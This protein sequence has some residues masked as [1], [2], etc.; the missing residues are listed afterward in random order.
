MRRGRFWCQD[1]PFNV[2]GTVP[3][4]L[5]GLSPQRRQNRPSTVELSQDR[6]GERNHHEEGQKVRIDM[7]F[8]GRMI[9]RQEVGKEIISKF[10]EAISDIAEV[11]K[12]AIPEEPD[13]GAREDEAQCGHDKEKRGPVFHAEPVG[14][15]DAG[16]E[17]GAVVEGAD[18]LEALAEPDEG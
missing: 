15:A 6:A 12:S 8:R 7:R 10:T 16:L 11:S 3:S 4:T 5:W 9:T 18:R 1:C 2:V 17:P 14:L 13:D